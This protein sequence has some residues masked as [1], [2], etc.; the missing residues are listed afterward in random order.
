VKRQFR[1]NLQA[2]V[3]LVA[4]T[5]SLV[6]LVILALLDNRSVRQN[7][8]D[9]ASQNLTIAAVQTANR[10]DHFLLENLLEIKATGQLR[11]FA[12][13]LKLAPEKRPGSRH[14]NDVATILRT[15]SRRNLLLPTPYAVLDAEG[16]NV[17]DT[18]PWH[19]GN[20]ESQ[21][22]YFQEPI[23]TAKP[24]VSPILFT[25]G[26]TRQALFFVSGP[27]FNVAGD[28]VGV[29][30]T[31]LSIAFL[32][33]F[34]ANTSGLAGPDSFGLLLNKNHFILA[35]SNSPEM[36]FKTSRRLDDRL[37]KQLQ[38][39]GQIP[40]TA[41]DKLFLE[42]PTFERALQ[43]TN[44]SMVFIAPLTP[45]DHRRN[46]VAA[47][48]LS[49][50]DWRVV[51]AQPRDAFLKPVGKQINSTLWLLCAIAVVVMAAA[52]VVARQLT[53]PIVNMT[54][55]ARQ[56]AVGD[57]TAKVP[58]TRRDE[59]GQLAQSFN[60]M[61]GQLRG[62]IGSL[63]RRV[64]DLKRAKS[65]S[66]EKEEKFR[67]L[68][69]SSSDLIWEVDQDG[70]YTY[71]SP[72]IM[73]ML[74]YTPEEVI[75]KT[76]FHFM[77]KHV[78]DTVRSQFEA[79]VDR[80]LPIISLENENRRKDG[81][82]VVLETNGVPILDDSGNLK[83]YRG[84]DR[85]ITKRKLAEI[86]LKKYR[87]H[88]ED[89]V[90]NRTAELEAKNKE[91]EVFTYSVS[92]DLKAPL[93]GIDGYSR[94]LV[95]DYADKFDEEG[96]LFLQ[97]VRK[98]TTQM[99]QL[100]EDLLAYSRMERRDLQL[101]TVDLRSIIDLLIAQREHEIETKKID[102][103]VNLAFQNLTSDTETLRQVMGNYLDN[104]IKFLKKK[105]NGKVD[106]GGQETESEWTLWVRDNG[107]GF[108]AQYHDRIF[109]IFQRLHRAE[110]FP[111]TGIGLAI[112][113]K[114][115]ERIGGRC[116]AESKLGEGATFFTFG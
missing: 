81:N 78:I 61:A 87:D 51:V 63:K 13:Y 75:G 29:L 14:E 102:V 30:R 68:V 2:K 62:L 37:F 3:I 42:L 83:G 33:D 58:M 100:I 95:E 89:L 94:L 112:V 57:L 28:V 5:L 4:L 31:Q 36:V 97:N 76:P 25:P 43:S 105:E 23:K 38:T 32:Q 109:N 67:S 84:V 48:G 52:V 88:L 10:I 47:A 106:I 27:I 110:D 59:L 77:P 107:I 6:P 46:Q 86:E 113:H 54:A 85:D 7:L 96:I 104:A 16:I 50:T 70:R 99:N 108:D 82:I 12:L 19:I 39:A 79:A 101:V 34:I 64:T 80:G 65:E 55:I 111:G 24:Y 114:A 49:Q 44:G 35:H 18:E 22:I 69:E 11:P 15:L 53:Q 40:Y 41:Q 60:D 8:T 115:I 93:R 20:D 90:K 103:S 91:L 116:W 56:I 74:G 73:N 1:F 17:L 72:K 71:V 26:S 9:V 92:H 21:K 66:R 45:G 98:S